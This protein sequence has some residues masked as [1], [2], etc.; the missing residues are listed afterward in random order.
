MAALPRRPHMVTKRIVSKKSVNPQSARRV[1]SLLE[2]ELG[3]AAFAGSAPEE[4]QAIG[5]WIGEQL[6]SF[7]PEKEPLVAFRCQVSERFA[8][9]LVALPDQPFLTDTVRMAIVRGGGNM[10]RMAHPVVQVQKDGDVLRLRTMEGAKRGAKTALIYVQLRKPDDEGAEI[11][12]QVKT[13][14][15]ASLQAVRDFPKMTHL[16]EEVMGEKANLSGSKDRENTAFLRW[17]LAGNFVFLGYRHY[18]YSGSGKETVVQATPRS[19]LGM[20]AGRVSKVK[21]ATRVESLG[22]SLGEYLKENSWLVISKT[23]E[24]STVHRPA[25]LDYVAVLERDKKGNV[26]GEHRWAGLYTSQAMTAHVREI[27]L[28]RG[29]VSAALAA[30][31]WSRH[32]HTYRALVNV[33]ETYARDELLLTPA[34]QLL[35]FAGIMAQVQ[36]DPH[37][38][39]LLRPSA[40]E[41]TVSAFVLLPLSKNSTAVRAKVQ[42]MLMD[43]CHGYDCDFRADL[44]GDNELARL[45]FRIRTHHWP[46]SVSEKELEDQ[47]IAMTTGWEEKLRTALEERFGLALGED[48]WVRHKDMGDAAYRAHTT[49]Q[50]AVEDIDRL[51]TTMGGSRAF[52]VYGQ[53]QGS[54][55]HL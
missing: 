24:K 38:R 17:L 49:A 54:C 45:F 50:E 26:T 3:A 55:L 20:F 1:L 32:G 16:L 37:P 43:A 53:A 25:A 31:P 22:D 13:G 18:H 33:L 41:Q 34:E 10:V 40:R 14:L 7:E 47:L 21:A 12:R 30:A 5:V 15:T 48:L 29:K 9:L 42:K 51:A 28:V 44:N 35:R 8:H 52:G 19:G 36:E 23:P 6:K 11:V 2:H 46:L 39:L 4:R 27:P